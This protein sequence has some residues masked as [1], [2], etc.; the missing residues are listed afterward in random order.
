MRQ[1]VVAVE[2]KGRMIG[3][4]RLDLLIEDEL[5]VELKAVE[6]FSAIHTAQVMSYLKTM[7]LPLALLINFGATFTRRYSTSCS[8][9]NL[10]AL[11]VLAVSRK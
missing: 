3:E 5:V 7:Q 10:G 2:Y 6:A 4:G 1:A 8:F 9:L 11:G